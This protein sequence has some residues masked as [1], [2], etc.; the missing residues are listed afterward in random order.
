VVELLDGSD[1]D[2]AKR[3]DWE[4]AAARR[5]LGEAWRNLGENRRAMESL[6]QASAFN[7]QDSRALSL[8]GELYDVEGQGEDIA[9][10]LCREAV[11]LDDS[12]WD[13]LHRLGQ[14]LY[15]QDFKQESIIN[16]Q[17]SLRL[18]C[19]NKEAVVL[20]EKIYR[21]IGKVRLAE[22]M[23]EKLAKL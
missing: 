23:A 5:C 19:R 21:E 14:V 7:P 2:R 16:L 11:E 15:R 17:G 1:A 10:S 20:L 18:N 22:R 13:N 8:L 3:E 9:L 6:Q 12:R 4:D